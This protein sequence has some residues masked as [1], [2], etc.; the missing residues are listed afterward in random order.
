MTSG[1]GCIHVGRLDYDTEGLML[2]TNDG[3]L[4]HRLAHPRYGVPKTY[5]AEVTGPCRRTWAGSSSA[6]SSWT[7]ASPA[8]TGSAW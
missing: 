7:T 5:L 1:N 2:L 6:V 3:E 4:A 8:L